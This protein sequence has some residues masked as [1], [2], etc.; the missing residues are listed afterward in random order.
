M[1]T[2]LLVLPFLDIENAPGHVSCSFNFSTISISCRS[3]KSGT[4]W[5]LRELG[6][7]IMLAPDTMD[8]LVRGSGCKL[9]ASILYSGNTFGL[10]TVLHSSIGISLKVGGGGGARLG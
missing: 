7:R 1:D 5:L 8:V 10:L 3:S 9:A 4:D 2:T 6:V